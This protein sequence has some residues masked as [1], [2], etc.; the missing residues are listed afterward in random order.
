M[1]GQSAVI[2]LHAGDLNG[3]TLSVFRAAREL[4]RSGWRFAYWVPRPSEVYDHLVGRGDRVGGAP[5][6]LEGYSLRALRHPPGVRVKLAGFPSYFAG[7][8]RFLR[9]ERPA[10]V[11]ANTL[12]AFAEA[13]AARALGFPVVFH[14]H[15]IAPANFKT[16]FVRGVARLTGMHVAA[17]SEATARRFAG[18]GPPPRIVYESAPVP[19]E[20]PP[21]ARDRRPLVVGS[22]GVISKRK[23][24]DVLVAAAERVLARRDDVR[25]VLVGSY[26]DTP[27]TPWA[28]AVLDRARAAGI[29]C[30]PR[31]DVARALREWDVFAIASRQDPFPL[32]VLEAMAHGV[33]V[34]GAA[35]DGI[36]E[37]L[38]DETGV[39]VARE[40]PEALAT[41]IERLLDTPAQARTAMGRAARERVAASFTPFHQARALGAV[42]DAATSASSRS[43]AAS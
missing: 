29:E 5:R 11:H 8:A 20:D 9:S 36:V 30:L 1:A 7:F 37:Q 14:L 33:P 28:A 23:G 6:H 40:D 15:E 2:V 43:S 39:L 31:A 35:S 13:V 26:P 38:T 41:G 25:F 19:D 21:A 4:E 3:A 42:Y 32:V 17:A 27:E 18:D 22:V 16:P 34:V 10:V 24:T 12:F